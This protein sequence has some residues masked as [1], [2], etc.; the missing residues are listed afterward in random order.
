MPP[1][2]A[3]AGPAV[4]QSKVKQQTYLDSSKFYNTDFASVGKSHMHQV[5]T[6]PDGAEANVEREAHRRERKRHVYENLHSDR[7]SITAQEARRVLTKS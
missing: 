4:N 7:D 1:P 6:D 3:Q 5:Y 2:Y